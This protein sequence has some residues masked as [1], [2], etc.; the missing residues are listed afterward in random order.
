MWI[1]LIIFVLLTAAVSDPSFSVIQD[2]RTLLFREADTAKEQAEQVQAELY[3]PNQFKSAMKYYKEA[4]EDYKKNKKPEE[5]QEKVKLSAV[6]FLK[7]VESTKLFTTNLSHCVSARNDALAAEAPQFRKKLWDEAESAFIKATEIMEEGNLD[8]ARKKADEAERRFRQVELESIKANYLDETRNLLQANEKELRRQTPFTFQKAHEL[9]NKAEKLLSENRYDT[10]EARQL[11]QEAKYEVL[12][13]IYLSNKIEQMKDENIPIESILLDSETPLKQISDEFDLNPRFNKGFEE[14][15]TMIIEEIQKLKRN[16]SSLQQDLNDKNEQITAMSGQ[17]TSMESQLGDLKSKEA[18][19]SQLM[20][21]QKQS[22]EK[23]IRIEEAFNENEAQV[24]RMGDQVIIRLYGLTFPVGR[25]TIEPQYYGLL[26][27]VLKASDEYPGCKITVEGHTD[28]WGSDK[29]NQK[30]ST[31]RANAVREYLLA[32]AGIDSS[33]VIAVGYG[34]TK[35]IATNET[36]EGRRK[37]RRID[38][39][40]LPEKK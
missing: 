7:S 10:D 9:A 6:F 11:A 5:I 32:T 31:E 16:M 17:I 12:H 35:P 21:Q 3:S 2:S 14:A 23:F 28:S 25:S 4:E 37:N 27:K 39:M 8:E 20:E 13:S 1:I 30:L 29:T 24:L 34:E 18:S 26:T 40:L 36:K 15:T 22:R 38:I 19:L 33:R